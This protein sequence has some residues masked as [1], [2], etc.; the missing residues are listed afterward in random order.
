MLYYILVP[1]AWVLAHIVFRPQV[2]GRENLIKGR[3]FILAPNHRSALD[4]VFIVLSDG[5][6]WL[7]KMRIFAK[8]ELFQGKPLLAWFLRQM[9][10]VSVKNGRDDLSTLDNTIRECRTGRGLLLFPEGTRSK[11][12]RL[13]PPKS[14]AF[15]VADQAAVDMIPCRILYDTPDGRL[16][17]FCRIRICFGKPISAEQLALGEKRNMVKLRENK[18]MLTAA[19]EEMGREY[20]FFRCVPANAEK[21]KTE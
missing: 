14:G 17:L 12:G 19:W 3:G 20:A 5:Y 18:K 11:D 15:V 8:K 1:L 21:E 16:K 2:I 10:A 7:H 6:F 4:P 9:G 13:L